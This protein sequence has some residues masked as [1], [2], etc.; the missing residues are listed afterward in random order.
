VRLS[1][2]PQGHVPVRVGVLLPFS[3]GSAATRALAKAMLNAAQLAMF[4]SRNPEIV[5]MPE[6][7]GS[8]PKEAAAAA[9]TLLNEGAE[10][11]VGPVFAPSVMAVAPLARDHG[12][13]LISFSTDRAVAGDGVYLL[14]FQPEAEVRRVI[15]YAA[16]HGHSNFTAI[17]PQNAYG[18]RIASAFRAEATADH[19]NVR[20][21]L[22]FAPNSSEFTQTAQAATG[23]GADA[24]LI[25]QGGTQ[26]VAIAALLGNPHPQ[27]LGTGLWE[28]KSTEHEVA[29]AGGWFAAP[30][31][32][33]DTSFENRYRA[34]FGAPPPQLAPLAYDAIS[35]VSALSSSRPYHRF[36]DAALTDPDGFSGVTGIFRFRA[37]GSCER[38]LAILAV[39][40][41]GFRIVDPAPHTFQPQAS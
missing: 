32:R 4:D 15:S 41:E 10:I 34:S 12:V 38:G 30:P 2:I 28:Q 3:N 24:I 25:A 40:P 6:D 19:V 14:S 35:L 29:L 9:R 21:I 5:L 18:D 17:V 39:G 37:D 22:R 33:A 27:L 13:P 8:T 36:T 16:L 20:A 1:N 11:I 26:L 31:P 23:S 7:E